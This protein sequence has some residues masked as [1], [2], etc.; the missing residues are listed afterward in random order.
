MSQDTADLD[1]LA[2]AV[3][4]S[5]TLDGIDQQLAVALYR[6]L[7]EG[8]PV[9]VAVLAERS[10]IGESRVA[11]TLAGWPGVFFD[12][13]G[14]V[15]GFW[16]LT[17]SETAHGY[18]IGGRQLSTWCAWDT[19]FITPILDQLAEVSSSCPV[20]GRPVSLTVGPEA[21]DESNPLRPS[22]PSCRRSSHGAMTSSPASAATSSSSPRPRRAGN[23][24]TSTLG[25]FC[26]AWSTP[27]RSA[28]GST[29]GAWERLSMPATPARRHPTR[30]AVSFGYSDHRRREHYARW[31]S[32]HRRDRAGR[33]GRQ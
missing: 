12:D 18:A 31:S 20:T 24:W 11:A 33:A 1:D 15:I 22:C 26:S 25:R 8:R 27:S 2:A 6:A 19:L 30:L 4:A 10:G 17:L 21:C 29:S 14:R 23:G 7:A 5:P 9:P 3:G 32:R 28:A 16:G 13:D